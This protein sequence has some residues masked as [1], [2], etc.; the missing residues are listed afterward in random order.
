MLRILVVDENPLHRRILGAMLE[1]LGHA[2]R[3]AD[4]ATLEAAGAFD[5]ALVAA[6]PEGG[7]PAAAQLHAANPALAIIALSADG[8]APALGFPVQALRAPVR[9]EEL[10][11]ALG[12]L[13]Q[14]PAPADPVLIDEAAFHSF[15]MET[16]AGDV[17]FVRELIGD[18]VAETQSAAA[19]IE[20]ALE[21]AD[22]ALAT[23]LA[24]TLKSTSRTFGANALAD[25]CAAAERRMQQ[26]DAEAARAAL[27]QI[28]ELVPATLRALEAHVN[29]LGRPPT[30]SAG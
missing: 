22:G 20:A 26:G 24:H 6:R 16:A 9:F 17:D 15:V 25:V 1:R 28:R 30:E 18:Y 27:P 23:R 29:G 14:R 4:G 3:A 7:F 19:Q 12:G 11:A 13:P 8:A 10:A 21:A 2:Y 5:A